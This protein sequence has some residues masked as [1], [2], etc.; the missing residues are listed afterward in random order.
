MKFEYDVE[1]NSYTDTF[2]FTVTNGKQSRA[3]YVTMKMLER[4]KKYLA[5]KLKK[6][7]NEG[8]PEFE[9]KD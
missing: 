8:V 7:L 4:D 9:V 3:F 5:E 6:F 1:Y 2:E